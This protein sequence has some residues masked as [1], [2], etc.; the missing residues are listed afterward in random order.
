MQHTVSTLKPKPIMPKTRTLDKAL[1]ERIRA[2]ASLE[3]RL[4]A[5]PVDGDLHREAGYAALHAA[6]EAAEAVYRGRQGVH[7]VAPK[8]RGARAL[9]E[10]RDATLSL[11]RQIMEDHVSLDPLRE[12]ALVLQVPQDAFEIG[13]SATNAAVA[14]LGLCEYGGVFAA[15]QVQTLAFDWMSWREHV[16]FNARILAYARRISPESAAKAAQVYSLPPPAYL[17][18]GAIGNIAKSAY[19]AVAESSSA[20]ERREAKK[21]G[22]ERMN[23]IDETFG[24]DIKTMLLWPTMLAMRAGTSLALGDRAASTRFWQSR[25]DVPQIIGDVKGIEPSQDLVALVMTSAGARP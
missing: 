5:F 1:S 10:S 14:L 12:L 19:R 8:L 7:D 20:V 6:R 2:L 11:L 13:V 18:A 15:W 16:D 22:D 25:S 4:R 9:S 21:M 3:T 17:V 23:E 24:E